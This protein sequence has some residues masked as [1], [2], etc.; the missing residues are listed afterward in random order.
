[1]S[2]QTQKYTLDEFTFNQFRGNPDNLRRATSIANEI[3]KA[4]FDDIS[5][6]TTRGDGNCL[7]RSII[8]HLFVRR[9][10]DVMFEILMPLCGD[11]IAALFAFIEEKD[12]V[13]AINN[14]VIDIICASIRAFITSKWDYKGEVGYHM[15]DDAIDGF[16][17][18]YVM[19]L[20]GVNELKVYSLKPENRT[21]GTTIYRYVEPYLNVFTTD[22]L[23]A[24]VTPW[25]VTLICA[26]GR[27]H[28][29]AL[30]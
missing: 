3:K 11:N 28:Y 5:V 14:P 30:I 16:A 2:S 7:I 13:V 6:L 27:C 10:K 4:T 29:S 19:R 26:Q 18:L 25:T 15:S 12:V 23:I 20:L 9:T 8:A 17:V 24:P 1:M 21:S 22:K